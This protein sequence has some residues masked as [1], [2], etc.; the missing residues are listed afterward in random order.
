M[1]T[2]D[3]ILLFFFIAALFLPSAAWFFLKPSGDDNLDNRSM[4]KLPELNILTIKEFPKEYTRYY[5]DSLP[6]RSCLI[7]FYSELIYSIFKATES[8]KVVYGK[9]GWLFYKDREDGDPMSDYKR[10]NL[11]TDEE[12]TRITKNLEFLQ[13]YSK[14][15]GAEF[16]LFIGPNKESI[17]GEYM[18]DSIARK[19]GRS[20]TEQ[21]LNH[22]KANTSIR[23]VFP[24]DDIM[25][26]KKNG[27]MYYKTD[28]HWNASGGYAASARLMKEFEISMPPV[29]SITISETEREGI[30][31]EAGYDL[32]NVSG[33]KR[34]MKEPYETA[35]SG[36]NQI[37]PDTDPSDEITIRFHSDKGTQGKLLMSRD[38]FAGKMMP[39]ISGHFKSCAYVL[40]KNFTKETIDQEKPDIVIY[41]T[42]ERYLPVLARRDF[43]KNENFR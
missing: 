19:Q 11:F 28:C 35:V 25:E 18:P 5:S 42:V 33:V 13:K 1:K 10:I 6:F 22:L 16:I 30:E 12:L 24:Y 40:Y 38:S 32:Q 2:S 27:F 9:D 36:Y 37:I 14:D 8:E 3:K 7:T 17:Y 34:L 31:K 21:L 41:E 4:G 29:S 43:E 23:T 39:V 15:R 20:R 26:G